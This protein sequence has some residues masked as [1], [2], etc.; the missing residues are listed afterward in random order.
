LICVGKIFS[1]YQLRRRDCKLILKAK[2][3]QL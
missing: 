3:Y 1:R 2:V